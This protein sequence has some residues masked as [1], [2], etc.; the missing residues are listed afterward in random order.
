MTFV[1]YSFTQHKLDVVLGTAVLT[2]RMLLYDGLGGNFKTVKLR[3]RQKCC[4]VC[5]QTPSLTRL[6][7]YPMWCQVCEDGNKST[8]LDDK[9][10]VCCHDY[11]TV[12]DSQQSHVLLDVRPEGE[13]E[14]CHLHNATSILHC[15]SNLKFLKN[16]YILIFLLNAVEDIPL[17][18]LE[19]SP[20]SCV[21]HVLQLLSNLPIPTIEPGKEFPRIIQCH[22]LRV[23]L[24]SL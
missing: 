4:V 9:D 17:Q 16:D 19:E 18:L 14:I 22:L 3:S 11:K 1:L 20:T 10:R 23:D 7:N 24:L 6:L 8:L 13:F 12:L 5:G 15:L 2:G 21:E